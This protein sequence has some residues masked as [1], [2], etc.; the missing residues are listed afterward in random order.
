M[1]AA[2]D[3]Y[4][5][6]PESQISASQTNVLNF[7]NIFKQRLLLPIS[8]EPPKGSEEIQELNVFNGQE[9]R[10]ILQHHLLISKVR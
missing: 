7:E 6:N 10:E 4:F 8:T 1:F 5:R 2:D 9:L 3:G